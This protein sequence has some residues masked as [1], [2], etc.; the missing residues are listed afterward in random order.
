MAGFSSLNEVVLVLEKCFTR[1]HMGQ[2]GDR[3][4]PAEG[5]RTIYFVTTMQMPTQPGL[6]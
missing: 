2:L 5:V 6:I 4:D 1:V 3:M